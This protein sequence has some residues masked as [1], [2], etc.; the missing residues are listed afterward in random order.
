[1]SLRYHPPASRVVRIL[2]LPG[3]FVF[4]RGYFGNS[5]PAGVV[6]DDGAAAVEVF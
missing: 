3:F 4:D 6:G 5:V 1:M 2:I